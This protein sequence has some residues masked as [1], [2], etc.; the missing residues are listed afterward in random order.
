MILKL[1]ERQFYFAW[2]QNS[3]IYEQIQSSYFIRKMLCTIYIY[4]IYFSAQRRNIRNIFRLLGY[5]KPVIESEVLVFVYYFLFSVL[6]IYNLQYR[7]V[8]ASMEHPS[9]VIIN[10]LHD[11]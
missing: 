4:S 6:L 11:K 3:V 10:K 8:A 9:L 7:L 2:N 1:T 5:F